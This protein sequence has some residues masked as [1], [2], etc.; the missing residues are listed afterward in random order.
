M[1]MR[2]FYPGI[3]LFKLAGALFVLVAHAL[4]IPSMAG[5]ELSP[6]ASFLMLAGRIVVPCFYVVSGFLLY[7]G[8]SHSAN[9]VAYV[10]RYIVRIAAFYAVFC[11][12]FAFEFIVP[13]LAR[14]GI[15]ISNLFLQAKI[16]FMAV[17][18]NGPMIQL[19]F[20][21]PLLFGAAAAYWMLNKLP[22]RKVLILTASAYVV[23]QL[24]SGSFLGMTAALPDTA[25]LH[26]MELGLTRYLGFGLT[27]VVMGALIAKYEERFLR[28]RI[29]RAIVLSIAFTI[30]ETVLLVSFADWTDAYKLTFGMIPNTALLFY[31]VLRVRSSTMTAH[32]R[33]IHLFSIVAFVGHIPFMRLNGLILGWGSSELDLW[34]QVLQTALTIAQCAALSV[35]I[36]RKRSAVTASSEGMA[37]GKRATITG[38]KREKHPAAETRT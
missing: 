20:I 1:L 2:Q 14:G 24:L 28:L 38:I 27:F 13:A 29:R 17:F 12:L 25:P 5:M 9:P 16:M 19:W 23:I 11:L 6:L 32:H 30:T 34:Q 26:Y 21:P 3:T 37:S 18:V 33:F 22:V 31:G 4:L 10:K 36:H 35:F 8:W 15:G 7:K